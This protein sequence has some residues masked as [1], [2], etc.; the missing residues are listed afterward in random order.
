MA[1]SQNDTVVYSP[2]GVATAAIT[3]ARGNTWAI[4]AAGQVAVN[5]VID[6]TTGNVVE[7]AYVNGKIW[8]ENTA[9]LW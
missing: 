1:A 3:D 2:P 4:N 7:L 8:Q 6:H 9:G 5:G